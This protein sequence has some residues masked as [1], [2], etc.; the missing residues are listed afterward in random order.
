MTDRGAASASRRVLLLHGAMSLAATWWRAGPAL[1][2]HGWTVVALDLPWHGGAP[3]PTGRPD[4]PAFADDVVARLDG[5][6]AAVVGHSLGALVALALVRRHDTGARRLVLEDPPSVSAG[7]RALLAAG[8]RADAAAVV[9]DRASVRRRECDANPRWE[10]PDVEHSIEGIE[11]VDV[12]VFADAVAEG[13]AWDLA[14]MVAACPVPVHVLAAR[15]MSASFAEGGG[16]A[17]RE[18]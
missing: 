3:R 11:R 7:D 16:T 2:R 18:P 12:G 9:A 5:P 1:E 10:E 8:M 4:V 6:V 17:L 15:T 14:G 13:L